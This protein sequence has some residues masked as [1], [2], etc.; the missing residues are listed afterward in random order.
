MFRPAR[1]QIILASFIIPLLAVGGWIYA[2]RPQPV[3]IASYVPESALGY[4]EINNWPQLLDS[5]TSTNAWRQLAP[6]YGVSDKLNYIGKIGQWDLIAQIT[7][8]GEAAM[9]AR[10]QFAIVVTGLEVRG[11]EVKPRLALIAET[12]SKPESLGEVMERRL[13]E[14]ARNVFGQFVKATD[15]YNGVQI[16]AYRAENSE[17]Q[18][19]SAQI[20]GELILAN[21]PDPL[22][23]CID[24]RLGRAPSMAGNFYLQNA[25]PIVERGDCNGC[26]FGFVTGEGVTRL[27]RFWAFLL[28]GDVLSK[29]ALAGAMGDVFTEFSTRATDGIAYGANFEDGVVVDRYALMLK[30]E[31]ADALKTAIKP[32]GKAWRAPDVIPAEA[33]DVTL[34]G[35]ENPMKTLDGIEAAISARIGAAQSFLLRQFVLGAREAFLGL[36]ANDK[37]EEAIGDEIANFNTTLEPEDRVWLIAPRDR[38]FVTTLVERVFTAQGAVLSREKYE[39]FEIVSSSDD[40]RGA[41]AFVGDFL[42][43]GKRERLISL[44]NSQQRGQNIKSA[45]RFVAA[46]RI[47]PPAAVRSF[48][49]VKNES[50]EMMAVIARWLATESGALSTPPASVAA[51]NQLPFAASATSVNDRGIYVEARSPFGNFPFLISLADS[52]MKT[53][54]ANK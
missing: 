15:R 35:V 45:P 49:S 22:R 51:L 7:G 18:L 17:K 46:N 50:G 40:R 44:I 29:A 53:E 6:A 8:G 24:T 31:V 34:V 4:L 19:V 3:V 47:S 11:E 10:A 32:N 42:A 38:A 12:H 16:T 37:A 21:H 36:K 39:G 48:T 52:S 43:I 33:A 41:A 54:S 30:P 26:L 23:A 1:K 5:F 27:L 13:P 28:S 9:L 2:R 25:R 14:L 20:E